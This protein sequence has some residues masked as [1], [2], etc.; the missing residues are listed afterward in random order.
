MRWAAEVSPDKLVKPL[1]GRV[2]LFCSWPKWHVDSSW[3][4][5]LR[6]E[7]LELERYV[8]LLEP[9]GAVWLAG[10]NCQPTPEEAAKV[11]GDMEMGE[12]A[13]ACRFGA[14]APR[15]TACLSP[16]GFGASGKRGRR[17]LLH[18]SVPVIGT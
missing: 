4:L 13:L 10:E 11:L 7:L 5:L 14:L 12:E 3:P 18:S 1:V 6:F 17:A 9:V 2:A 15:W 16:A 8:E